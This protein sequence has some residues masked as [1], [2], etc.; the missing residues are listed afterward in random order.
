MKIFNNMKL[1]FISSIMPLMAFERQFLLI[2]CR[3]LNFL[4]ISF[5]KVNTVY[6][7]WMPAHKPMANNTV[8]VVASKSLRPQVKKYLR[9]AN[10]IF[11]L[12]ACFPS[13]K[14]FESDV[15]SICICSRR[16]FC[17]PACSSSLTLTVCISCCAARC[18]L[19]VQGH[20]VCQCIRCVYISGL[21]WINGYL[22]LDI[23]PL[24]L[25]VLSFPEDH[26]N[27]VCNTI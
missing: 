24:F 18:R 3:S 9:Q 1:H 11:I 16:V 5:S 4:P 10:Y 8:C 26:C 2:W 12:S 7:E 23:C 14:M 22:S 27:M 15:K 20:P 19:L 25:S 17:E 13:S 6:D 21:L